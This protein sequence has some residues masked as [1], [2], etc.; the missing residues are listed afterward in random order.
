MSRDSTV[1]PFRLPEAI[2][3]PLTEVALAQVLIA[4]ADSFVAVWKD[5]KLP[6]AISSSVGSRF[7]GSRGRRRRARL[8]EGDR[9]G[10][11]GHQVPALLGSQDRQRAEQGCPLGSAQHEGRPSRDYGAPTRAAAADKY[12]AKYDKVS[13][14]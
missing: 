5:L 14:E 4:E 13:F 1:I 12:G 11:S 7:A 2:D 3:D 6:D 8:L 10:L 9:R